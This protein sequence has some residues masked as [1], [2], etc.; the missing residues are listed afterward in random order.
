MAAAIAALVAILGFVVRINRGNVNVRRAVFAGLLAVAIATVTACSAV[1]E[2]AGTTRPNVLWVVWDTVR[3]DHLSVYGYHKP[4][5]PKLENWA[6]NARV[7]EQCT[8]TAGQTLPSTASM[9]TGLFPREHGTTPAWPRLDDR[10]PTIAELFRDA[11]YRTYL[12]SAN[13]YISNEHNFHRGFEVEEH[14]WD[15]PYMDD[16]LHIVQAKLDS[17]THALGVARARAGAPRKGDV[18]SSGAL[19]RRGLE[20]WLSASDRYKPFFAFVNY[21]EAHRPCIPPRKYR[22]RLMP[23]G[24]VDASY[25]FR[26]RAREYTFGLIEYTAEEIEL[27][28]GLYDAA[29]AELDDLFADL[30]AGLEASGHLE[31]TVVVLTADHGEHLGDHRRIGHQFSVY[32]ALIHVP[33]IVYHPEQLSP[34]RDPRRVSTLDVFSTLLEL[35]GIDP[36]EGAGPRGISWLAPKEDRLFFAEYPVVHGSV[37]NFARRHP[38]RDFGL[39]QRRLRAIYRGEW[40]QI[41]AEDGAREL[42]RLATDPLESKNLAGVELDTAERM[43]ELLHGF[44]GSLDGWDPEEPTPELSAEQ[45]ER[46]EALGY[47]GND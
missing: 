5:T 7:F 39:W 15:P 19:A 13:A 3:A 9:F 35:A 25:D 11:G 41:E 22:E 42:Y 40:K 36:P 37:E 14:P 1:P 20:Q 38:E 21:M 43:S 46:L 2:D 10:F 6:E 23:P 31:N 26:L 28:R 24:Q 44:V 8:A 45:Y 17:G 18:K 27:I 34:G 12:F 30:L 33:L 32:E 4:T 16:A 47:V 29:L